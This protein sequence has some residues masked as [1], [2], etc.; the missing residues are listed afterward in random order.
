MTQQR[1][2][3]IVGFVYLAIGV[4]VF[5][6]LISFDPAD[7]RFFASTP[8]AHINNFIGIIGAYIGASL[9]FL[10]GYSAYVIPVLC[11]VWAI[12]RFT[13][14]QPQRS[15]VKF[16]GTAVL[17]LASSAFMSLLFNIENTSRM[18]AGGF[19]GMM[20]SLMLE[21][22]FGVIGSYVIVS[23][24]IILSVLL[25]TELLIIPFAALLIE[26]L[27]GAYKRQ[28]EISNA[29]RQSRQ[30]LAVNNSRPAP[31]RSDK[32]PVIRGPVPRQMEKETAGIARV[33][34][35]IPQP[36]RS[37]NE[38]AAPAIK[39]DKRHMMAQGRDTDKDRP[40]NK[41]KKPGEYNLPTLDL[42]D[43]PPPVEERQIKEDLTASSAVLEDTL[44]DFG[45]E[46]K[47]AQV[48]KGP[49]ITRYEL[50]PSPGV[51]VNRITAL[52]D[53]IALAMKAQSV[54]IIAPIPGKSRV[55]IE[56][57]NTTA[58]LVFLKE[59]LS[60][61]EF[62]GSESK[63]T[64]ALGK[65][66]AGVPV[67]CDLAKMPHLL[68]A[69]TTGAGKTV[70]VNSIVLSMLFNASPEEL[71]LILVDPKMVE[72]AMF[73]KL[74]HLICPVLTNAK[75]VSGALA[76]LVREMESRYRLLAK[77]SCRNIAMFNQKSKEGRFKDFPDVPS[78][79]YYIV[80]VIDELADLMAVASN[81]IESAIARLAQLSRAVGIH[82]ILATQRPSVDVIT[83]VIKANFPAR[84]SFKVA[85]K[86]DSRTV[87]D[88][89][90]ADKLLGR[91]D[92]LF[93][94]PG[95]AK[96]TRAQSSLVSDK[97]IERVIDFI[98]GQR[99]ANYEE[100]IIKE[101]GRKE[102]VKNAERDEL[103]DDAVRLVMESGQA[104]VS[105]LQRR[106]RLSYTRAARLIDS[107]EEEGLIG[108]YCGS[109]PR[110][111]LVD[112]K[113]YLGVPDKVGD[114]QKSSFEGSGAIDGDNR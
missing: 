113:Q 88:M 100:N 34:G 14:Q 101:G 86:V 7:I 97:E 22:Y 98:S 114:E 45:I 62:E 84:I 35:R 5:V 21:R 3:E 36:V 51:K 111:I 30:A 46:V 41:P 58:S 32:R 70:C 63:L 69:G 90:G 23:T 53:D 48:E 12:D 81:E 76:W 91:G 95:A 4:L 85:S 33:D 64:L 42:L 10:I 54:R 15:L 25:A 108:P 50:E 47:V 19:S 83:G 82:I 28:K 105:I 29:K 55:G 17:F 94:E 75:K 38:I 109:K 78:F 107:M 73:N 8:N 104:S 68:I 96:P 31:A 27:K 61:R 71:K 56:V 59:V 24:L 99:E 13:S 103:F 60:S 77:V 16:S 66:T 40:D 93:M 9:F 106:L 112:R 1:I 89:N 72:M 102:F 110:D 6:S 87:L 11:L 37:R 74:P 20:L 79:M 39:I 65:D 92:M 52:N 49:V 80:L 57:P 18:N 43:S 2:N 44:R 26:R 67:V